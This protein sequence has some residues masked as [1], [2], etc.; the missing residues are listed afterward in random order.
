MVYREWKVGKQDKKKSDSLC[1]SLGLPRLVCDVLVKRGMDEDAAA[2]E[3]LCPSETLASP[4]TLKNMSIA[5]KRILDAVDK[6]ERI[7]VFGDY[8][9][10]GVSATALL[11]TYLDGLGADV[12]YKLP[13]REDDGYGLSCTAIDELAEK[14]VGLIVTV[15]NGVSAGE[16]ID[17]AKTKG[18]DVVVTDHHLPPQNLPNAV[19]IVDPYLNGDMSEFKPLAGVGVAFKLACALEGCEADELMPFYADLVAIG[20][21]GDIMPLTGENRILVRAGV[22]LMQSSDRPGLAALIEAAGLGGK[23]LTA[24]N[25]SFG[26][27]PRLNAA[28]RMDSAN[29]AIELLLCDDIDN[30]ATIVAKILSNNASRQETEQSI[31]DEIINKISNDES[32][33]KDRI[34]VV[35]GKGYHQGVIG[36]V[37]S[38]IVERF[39]KPTIVISIDE[40]GVGKGSGRSVENMSL[41]DAI[42]S[43]GELLI[44]YG[45]HAMAAGLSVDEDKIP[46]LRIAINKY[47]S[48][49]YAKQRAKILDIDA[50]LNIKGLTADDVL[51]LGLLAPFGA[52]NPSPVFLLED[53]LLE[54]AY[55]VSEGKHTRVRL[56]KGQDSIYSMMFNVEPEAFGIDIGA[57]VDAAVSLSVFNGKSGPMISSRVV[58]LRP[59]GMTALHTQFQE[60]YYA[61]MCNNALSKEQRFSLLP[62]R[63]FVAI[64]YRQICAKALSAR[65][66]RPVF[67]K[68]GEENTGRV[69]VALQALTQ[70]GLINKLRRGKAEYYEKAEVKEKKNLAD[71]LVLRSLED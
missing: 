68:L 25:I 71:A 60:L 20:T 51:Q 36:I 38:R 28:G 45:G 27:A 66:L 17:Y 8:D 26:I 32:Y 14:G 65:D 3:F 2:R 46:E 18:I 35:S 43:C 62:S 42:A 61:L 9:V 13:N 40:D 15:D 55:A 33:N 52:A 10:D 29:T 5:C 67:A 22:E 44:R 50:R 41:Y 37:A 54:G 4:F 57:H 11:Y 47:A 63:E 58:E 31:S 7:A 64:V 39:G 6:M 69:L 49:H 12:I 21:V 70:L 48:E 59:S 19:A 1:L 24:E 23:E 53:M 16:A 34:L 56:V 30:A